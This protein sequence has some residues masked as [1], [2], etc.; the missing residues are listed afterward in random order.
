MC[1]SFAK[2]S[3]D[4][5]AG[6]GKKTPLLPATIYGGLTD[7][8]VLLISASENQLTS[9]VVTTSLYDRL[10]FVRRTLQLM[11]E[12]AAKENRPFQPDPWHTDFDTIT[13]FFVRQARKTFLKEPVN[14]SGSQSASSAEAAAPAVEPPPSPSEQK[15]VE[16]TIEK[17]GKSTAVLHRDYFSIYL[18]L[19]AWCD[20]ND[21]DADDLLSVI[22]VD[23]EN[24]ASS[25]Q[26][27]LF[28]FERLK[29]IIT[30]CNPCTQNGWARG[31][32]K[33][34]FERMQSIKPVPIHKA[35][36]FASSLAPFANGGNIKDQFVK[37]V[38][39]NFWQKAA[40]SM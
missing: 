25:K 26:K 29:R 13:S 19:L 39:A 15:K 30:E 20:S 8:D 17:Q 22:L 2:A 6:W 31:C 18:H 21:K 10:M 38:L 4:E 23:L 14:Q 28:S 11:A 33:D 1:K 7:S 40:C 32:F 5:I 35:D 3:A 34:I 27:P 24:S 9:T 36:D 16:K 37:P 12:E